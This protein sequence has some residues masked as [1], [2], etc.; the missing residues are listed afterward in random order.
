MSKFDPKIREEQLKLE[1]AKEYFSM[2]DTT[3]IIGSIDF[4]VA[5][6]PL[7]QRLTSLFTTEESLVW[8][9]AKSGNRQNIYH[10]LVQLILT[11]G[12]ARTFDSYL[13]PKYLAAF[14]AEKIAFIEY[15]EVMEIFTLNDFN[16]NVTPSDHCTAEFGVLHNLVQELLERQLFLFDYEKQDNELRQ[17]IKTNLKVDAEKSHRIQVN[18][19]NFIHIY[20]RWREE[21]MPHIAIDWEHARK[22]GII[23]ADFY[24][25]DLLSKDNET[26]VTS[27]FVLLKDDSYYLDKRIDDSGL[28]NFRTTSFRQGGKVHYD[29]FWNHYERPPR[30]EYWDYLISRRDLLVPQDI[31]ERKGAYFTPQKWVQLSQD[32]LAQTLGEDWQEDYYIWDCCAGTGNLLEGLTNKYNI[33]ASTLDKQDVDIMHERI[34]KMNRQATRPDGTTVGG[35]NLLK[36]YVFQFDFLNDDLQSDKVPESLRR[37]LADPEE[38]KKLVIYINPPYAETA[39]DRTHQKERKNKRGV[40]FTKMRDKYANLIGIATKELYAQFLTRIHQEIHGCIIAE[41]STLK[42]LLG[43][44]FKEFR[45]AFNGVLLN[46]FMVPADTFDNVGGDFPIGFKIWDSKEIRK[47]DIFELDVYDRNSDYLGKKNVV[48]PEKTLTDFYRPYHDRELD[49]QTLGAVG[50]YGSDFQH[51]RYIA[52]YNPISKPNRWTYVKRANLIFSCLYL[53]IRHCIPPNWINNRDQFFYPED[54]WQEDLE[55]QSD[56]LAYT[57]FHGQNKITNEEGTN[58]WIPF[59]EQEVGARQ[60]FECHFMTDFIQGRIQEEEKEVRPGLFANDEQTEAY[61]Y[62]GTRPIVFSPEAK[63]LFEAGR[64]LWQYYHKQPDAN[65]NASYYDIRAYFQGRDEKG[66]M[67]NRSEDE[68]YSVLVDNLRQTLN[69]LGAHKIAP[70]AY[71]YRFLLR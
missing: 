4:C 35:A 41:F 34:D 17:F 20:Q 19:N 54:G 27:L 50:L 29:Q 48:S 8:A 7:K 11:I 66:R 71:K 28:H 26:L 57:L 36:D 14:D 53:S 21:V 16:W 33:Y 47:E 9:E 45:R 65:P 13:P 61:I 51:S 38:R 52:I 63:R 6:P 60:R 15:S 30:R 1:L 10:S 40:S 2:Y 56:C 58:H 69:Y 24:L 59:T 67:N 42:S 12:R 32:Y 18:K 3:R 49:N 44:N 62:D 5:P 23:G 39:S 31:R 70:K 43:A 25:A 37:I 68:T 46:G 64:K 55:F 22:A